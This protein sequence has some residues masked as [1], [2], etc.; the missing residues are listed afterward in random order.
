MGTKKEKFELVLSA[1]GV[2]FTSSISKAT[3][4]LNAFNK[5][6]DASMRAAKQLDRGLAGMAGKFS[7]LFGGI[8]AV[9]FSKSIWDAG[10]S[11]QS[12]ERGFKAITGSA[13]A[14]GKEIDFLRQTS[15]DLGLNFRS[16]A[17]AY[18]QLAAAAR[19]T[20][21][22]GKETREIFLGIS[23]AA[24]VLGLSA[25]NTSG[26][27]RAISQMM[28]K[29]SVQAEEL[30]GQLG[31][32]LPGA[33]PLAAKAMGVTTQELDKMLKRGQ[34]AATDL[35]PKL[36]QALHDLYGKAAIDQSDGAIQ[37]LN[38]FQNAWFDLKAGIAESG[39]L[40]VATGRIKDLTV[41]LNDPAVKK[42]IVE[43]SSNFFKMADAVLQFSINHGEA[44]AKV[45]GAAI[46]L[47]ALSR[48][49]H[50]LTGI[51]QGLNA[52]TLV[53]TG[54]RLLPYLATL[55]NS[56][57]MAQIAGMGLSGALGAAAGSTL[58]L[59]AGF[60]AGEWLYEWTEPAEKAL[61]D[62]QHELDLTAAKYRQFAY[63]QPA[64]QESLFEKSEKDLRKYEDKLIS[65]FKHQSAIVQK[66]YVQSQDKTFF[67]AVTDDARRAEVELV[68]AKVK[69]EQ[70]E[71]AMDEYGEVAD[72]TYSKISDAAKGSA[73]TQQQVTGAALEA[74]KKQYQA[75]ADKI[76]SLQDQIAGR[77]KSLAEELRAMSRTGMSDVGAWKDRKREAKEYATAARQAAEAGNFDKAVALA[78]QAKTAYKDLNEEVKSGNT[79]IISAQQALQT[80]SEGVRSA[81][82]LAI[83]I[84]K[85]Q[86]TAARSA[87]DALNEKSGGILDPEKITQSQQATTDLYEGVVKVGDTWQ[88]VWKE[89]D[90]QGTKVLQSFEQRLDELSKPREITFYI[91][92][93]QKKA[94]GG[95]A[96]KLA[97]G[98]RLPGYGGGDRIPALLEAGEYIIRKEAV[99]RFGAGIFHALNNLR[100]PEMPRFATGGPVAANGTGVAGAG[101]GSS[102]TINLYDH[103]AGEQATVVAPTQHDYEAFE[104]MQR[105]RAR[106]SSR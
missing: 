88:N 21:L 9:A 90:A 44:M 49:V 29:G 34:V 85:Q 36:A 4:G 10:V 39:F 70:I 27:L 12:L 3:K 94:A 58:A 72:V 59:M 42:R 23:E 7:A 46:A 76:K 74:M 105:K 15:D 75:Y 26:A 37:A 1:K 28:S 40:D 68:A 104:R 57:G 92:E 77:E 6:I 83:D 99:N 45:A 38:R 82:E 64:D 22:E 31:E 73:D 103:A 13:E 41:A 65:A 62:L 81:G 91:K 54:S 60:K 63:F 51:W 55:R 96:H 33:F 11:M 48:T 87:Q 101:G 67:G 69:L 24:T 47:S 98:G 16:S 30:R 18:K 78:D 14:A 102:V 79:V 97:A 80:S 106:L 2:G 43:L 71:T 8:S 100:L 52:A 19:G 25:D 66:L 17:D 84:L 95:M 5:E 35:L 32:R 50:L 53:I 93:V 89:T 20:A 86:E 56:L 61:R